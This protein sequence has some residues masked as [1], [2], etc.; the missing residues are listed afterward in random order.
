MAKGNKKI[1]KYRRPKNFNIGAFIFFAIFAYMT[2]YVYE[3]ITKEKIQPYEVTEG[4]IVNNK[5]YTG[6]IL[7]NETTAYLDTTG[8]INYYIREGK[9]AAA[10]TSIYSVD[11]SGT[12]ASI[13][14]EN[15]QDGSINKSE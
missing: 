3:Y 10:G 6:I 12:L 15:G 4:A 14:Q 5:K 13:I 9:R 1:V 11:E 7:R 8:Y 2:F